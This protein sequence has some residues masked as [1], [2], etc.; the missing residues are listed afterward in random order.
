MAAA[1]LAPPLGAATA[2]TVPAN[3]LDS[4][5]HHGVRRKRAV[6]PF[7]RVYSAVR[8]HQLLLGLI[9]A[10][11]IVLVSDSIRE[12]WTRAPAE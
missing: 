5:G 11:L 9:T 12:T 1:C 2:L 3:V 8:C 6:A 10:C 4:E 7:R